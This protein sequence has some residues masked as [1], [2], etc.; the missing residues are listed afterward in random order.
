MT[1]QSTSCT[2]PASAPNL[3]SATSLCKRTTY[4]VHVFKCTP[5]Q[6]DPSPGDIEGANGQACEAK[7]WGVRWGGR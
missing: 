7:W 5:V 4:L 3:L 2:W 1:T 6:L